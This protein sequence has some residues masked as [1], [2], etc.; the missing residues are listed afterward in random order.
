M[1]TSSARNGRFNQK[2]KEATCQQMGRRKIWS[3]D[4]SDVQTII[5][6][7]K[8]IFMESTNAGQ[9]VS[10]SLSIFDANLFWVCGFFIGFCE[11]A[12]TGHIF[13]HR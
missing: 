3:S 2:G 1:E 12:R 13:V 9:N 10:R 5:D 8:K 7:L 11:S 6:L 4:G